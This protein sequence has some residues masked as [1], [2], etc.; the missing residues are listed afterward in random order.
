[1]WL[2][3]NK[4]DKTVIVADNQTTFT[5]RTDGETQETEEIE[6][7]DLN[8]KELFEESLTSLREGNVVK[9]E[10]IQIDKEF[11]LVDIGYKSEGQ[12]RISE[13][14][15]MDGRLTVGVGDNVDVVLVS[16]EN[17]D[18][19]II[20]SKEKVTRVKIWEEIEKAYKNSDTIKG[21]IVSQVK[22]GLFVDIGL[23]AFLPGSQADLRP[24]KDLSSLVGTEHDFRVIKFEK[25][26]GNIVLS[27]RAAL[28]SERKALH[29]KTMERIQENEIVE[30]LVSNITDY[31]MFVDLGGIDGL[32]HITDISWGKIGH[33]SELYQVG[34]EINVKI[35]SINKE[36]KRVSLG[37][38]QLTS[39]P[40]SH[41]QGKYSVGSK[42]TGNIVAIQKYGAFVELE[43]GIQGLVHIS[44]ISWTEKIKH[45][46]QELSIGDAVE[47]VVI[48][49]DVDKKR[50]S[51][52]IKQLKKNPWEDIADNYPVGAI[53][54]GKIKKITDFGMF[55]GIAEGI[56]GLV[57]IS[58]ISWTEKINHPSEL[59]KKDDEVQAVILDI[60]KEN[61]RFSLGIKQLSSD[62][63]EEVTKKYHIGSRVRGVVKSL[64]DFGVFVELEPGIEGLI[65]VSQLPK[66]QQ[67]MPI[68]GFQ[69]MD[70]IGAEVVKIS[71]EEKKIGLSI[72]KLEGN[73]NKDHYKNDMNNKEKATSNLGEI[74]KQKMMDLQS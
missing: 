58:D 66:D 3:K 40:W 4:T 12:I 46:S 41:V 61:E 16:K 18:G 31:G 26:Q 38:K 52:S 9:G 22:G 29:K 45:P 63:W 37:I 51:L 49:V 21:K 70:E 67:T 56:D 65:H 6:S 14:M 30:G 62:P 15:D 25:D 20:L 44:E 36:R 33:P 53:I 57:H 39:D 47:A 60:D 69:V 23:Q 35:L 8:F 42:I 32:V 72:K 50:I 71:P 2:V 13:F 59:Y 10:I 34:D 17:K 54:A 74:L 48:D 73:G 24:V 68:N 11:V 28:E 19:R 43:E 55:I 5:N 27:R 1:M 7:N 64:T